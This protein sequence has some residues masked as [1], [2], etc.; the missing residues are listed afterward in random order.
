MRAS[1]YALGPAD[2]GT[3]VR[4]T[5]NVSEQVNAAPWASTLRLE[6]EGLGDGFTITVGEARQLAAILLDVAETIEATGRA[7]GEQR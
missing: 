2:D 3:L 1:M 4:G 5:L 7:A 6:V